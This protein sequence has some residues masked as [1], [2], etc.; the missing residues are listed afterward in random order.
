MNN[1]FKLTF[2]K[3]TI[4]RTALQGLLANAKVIRMCIR[5]L[6]FKFAFK[7]THYVRICILHNY[8]SDSNADANIA[9]SN[10]ST[11]T[12]QMC[13]QCVF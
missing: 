12:Y 8:H 9:T 4:G 3:L 7:C 6:S 1:N 13:H 10:V 11:D 2:Y 5:M